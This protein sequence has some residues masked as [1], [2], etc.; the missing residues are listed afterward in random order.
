MAKFCVEWAYSLLGRFEE[1]VKSHQ[2]DFS[3][4]FPIFQDVA[5]EKKKKIDKTLLQVIFPFLASLQNVMFQ[6]TSENQHRTDAH[7]A[8]FNPDLTLSL[9]VSHLRHHKNDSKSKRSEWAEK[10]K[11]T[12]LQRRHFIFFLFFFFSA[13]TS[14]DT[15]NGNG[16]VGERFACDYSSDTGKMFKWTA[17]G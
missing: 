4:T 2:Q 7:R 6:H 8:E 1:Q 5:R 12:F 10:K 3:T 14:R 17:E 16:S 9:L 11:K 13:P 15:R